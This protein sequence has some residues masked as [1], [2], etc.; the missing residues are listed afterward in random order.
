MN[1]NFY[2]DSSEGLSTPLNNTLTVS[3]NCGISWTW[4]GG[5][6]INP[7]LQQKS[8]PYIPERIY[9]NSFTETTIVK[10]NDG[11]ETKVTC[12]SEDNFSPESGYFAALAIKVFGNDKKKFKD[13]WYPVI[14]RRVILDGK[15]AKP[16][17]YGKWEKQRK[18]TKR[19]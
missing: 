14:S 17:D 1:K 7:I 8:N 16:V 5:T 18:E 19:K 11:T 9:C 4:V 10:W 3:D 2:I 13:F 12:D 6:D 15:K